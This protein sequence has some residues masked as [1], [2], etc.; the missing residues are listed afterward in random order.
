M[1]P[2]IGVIGLGFLNLVP[3][4]DR[5]N[6]LPCLSRVEPK[7]SPLLAQPQMPQL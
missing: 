7:L 3:A 5:K 4:L 2:I 1:N 6:L